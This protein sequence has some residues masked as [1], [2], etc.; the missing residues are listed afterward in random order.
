MRKANAWTVDPASETAKAARLV[1][2]AVELGRDDAFVLAAAGVV[3]AYVVRD[4]DAGAA[5]N[6][7]ALTLNPNLAFAWLWGGYISLWLGE[8]D[9][10]VG[11]VASAMRLSPLDPALPMMY[12]ATADAH[13][14]AGRYEE[15][16][17]WAAMAIRTPRHNGLRIAAASN[18]LAG[19]LELAKD[20][21]ARL[22]KLDPALRVSN[23]KDVQGP[24]R[25]PEDH[26]RYEEA[27]RKAGLPE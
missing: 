17:S 16:S 11:R 14:H 26:A 21:M 23:L 5:L 8:P 15:A 1:Q 24:Y 2:Q 27:M 20:A 25:R 10:A 6:E 19:R 3:L 13:F 18:A 22:R 4:L 12:A 7:R 9:V